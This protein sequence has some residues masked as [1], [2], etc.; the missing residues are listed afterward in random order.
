ME[1]CVIMRQRQL[2]GQVDSAEGVE[3]QT[4]SLA[5]QR[6]KREEVLPHFPPQKEGRGEAIRA[7]DEG[8]AMRCERKV[9]K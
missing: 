5:A 1:M 9:N 3:G 8:D 4:L 2:V 7:E 6:K